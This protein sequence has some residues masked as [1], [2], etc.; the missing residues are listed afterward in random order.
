ME[1][2]STC[3][4]TRGLRTAILTA[5]AVLLFLPALRAAE[6]GPVKSREPEKQLFGL[7]HGGRP[8][9]WYRFGSGARTGIVYAG[10]HG[11]YEWNTVLLARRLIEYF[12]QHP[13]QIPQEW[14]LYV[15]P[16][17]NPDGLHRIIGSEHLS[18]FDFSA[19][20]LAPGRFNGRGVDLNRNFGAGW[21]AQAYWGNREVD[22]GAKPFSEPETRALRKLVLDKRP[23]FLVSYHSAAGGIY[24]GGKRQEWQPA[25]RLA[26][27]YSRASGY[28]VPGRGDSLVSYEI[29]G[30]AAHY[31][32]SKNIPSITIEL[33]GR[34]G[35]EFE[36]N[37]AG[38]MRLFEAAEQRRS[39]AEPQPAR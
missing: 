33:A 2:S 16:N 5:A 15:I 37:L 24:Y 17:L 39:K 13:Q 10:I 30:A 22:P 1:C 32:Y 35:P 25:R 27:A 6:T 36:R 4:M 8:L 9:Y 11:G 34:S 7:S 38:L 20:D 23:D 28:P 18:G 21:Q 12:S 14:T 19:A 29:T 26:E 31:F 3:R